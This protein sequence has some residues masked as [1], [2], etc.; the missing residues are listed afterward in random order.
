[1]GK[2]RELRPRKK[3]G[4]GAKVK[5]GT[6]LGKGKNYSRRLGFGMVWDGKAAW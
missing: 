5:V 1:M 2:K 3:G 4:I 6:K